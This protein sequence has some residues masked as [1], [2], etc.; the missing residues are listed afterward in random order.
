ME[1]L[2]QISPT[3][4]HVF[5]QDHEWFMNEGTLR[6]RGFGRNND[7]DADGFDVMGYDRKGADRAGY[8][9]ADY[10]TD[11]ALY[12]VVQACGEE[13]LAGRRKNRTFGQL[14]A[15]TDVIVSELQA[16][17]PDVSFCDAHLADDAGDDVIV[18]QAVAG[19]NLSVAYRSGSSYI[20]FTTDEMAETYADDGKAGHGLMAYSRDPGDN[21][22]LRH[23]AKDDEELKEFVR[24]VVADFR[25]D[26]AHYSI[27]ITDTE[28]GPALEAVR[29]A[30]EAPDEEEIETA[31]M[32]GD[33]VGEVL[34]LS[35]EDAVRTFAASRTRT[36][37]IAEMAE[38]GL[39]A[40]Q[41]RSSAD[42]KGFSL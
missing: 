40:M 19:G 12:A 25:P 30:G 26:L 9:R 31:D 24:E 33:G 16:A 21:Y 37:A 4:R 32:N 8:T 18:R 1:D 34:A 35:E 17:F 15:T 5:E 13:I 42:A 10:D 39:A 2:S 3:V 36:R 14:L 38:R 11:G 41:M 20:A 23:Y 28:D 7:F 27:V 6:R 29:V 22:Q